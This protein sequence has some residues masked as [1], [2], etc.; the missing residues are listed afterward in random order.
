VKPPLNGPSSGLLVVDIPAGSGTAQSDLQTSSVQTRS[1]RYV[2]S[3][4]D[5]ITA[6]NDDPVKHRD[7]LVIAIDNTYRPGDEVMLTVQRLE[8][9]GQWREHTIPVQLDVRR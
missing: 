3:G 4:D 1:G 6:V 2:F 5:I 8:G 9:D 7:D